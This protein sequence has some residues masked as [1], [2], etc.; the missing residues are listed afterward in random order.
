METLQIN[1]TKC[2]PSVMFNPIDHVLEIKGESYP[3]NTS[4]FYEPI[5]EWLDSYLAQS[6]DNKITVNIEIIYFNSSSSK[7][8]MDFFDI[9][10][11]AAD[12]GKNIEV[13]WLYDEDNDM[14]LEYGEEFKEDLET[15]TF[16]LVKL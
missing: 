12:N 5:F 14:S 2:T 15:L 9:L 13:N 6:H 3:E 7:V 1:A 16:N 10:D 4:A 8:L 11:Q